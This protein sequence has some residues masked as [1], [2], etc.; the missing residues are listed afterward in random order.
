MSQWKDMKKDDIRALICKY[1]KIL[2]SLKCEYNKRSNVYMEDI[3]L[4]GELQKT[5]L[6]VLGI[7]SIDDK[8]IRT[9]VLKLLDGFYKHYDWGNSHGQYT[10]EL[11]AVC[12]VSEVLNH[13]NIKFDYEYLV[14]VFNLNVDS[15]Y[16]LS[17][18]I[19]EYAEMNYWRN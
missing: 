10:N 17:Y 9:D 19:N 8:T 11:L 14:D 12:V 4:P 3:Y 13:W 5:S 16:T 7:L 1:S 18:R 6:N 15:Y 2:R